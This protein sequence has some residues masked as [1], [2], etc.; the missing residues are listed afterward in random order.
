MQT[1]LNIKLVSTLYS[2]YNFKLFPFYTFE[3]RTSLAQVTLKGSTKTI[4]ESFKQENK[5]VLTRVQILLVALH[6]C[7]GQ[8]IQAW[9]Y[10]VP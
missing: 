9:I 2:Q 7:C 3:E 4:M 6:L 1:P 8:A 5:K 10:S